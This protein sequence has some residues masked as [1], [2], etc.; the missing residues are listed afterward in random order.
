MSRKPSTPAV[1][2]DA[3]NNTAIAEAGTAAT[4]L[5]LLA[6][7]STERAKTVAVQIGYEGT[8]T[9]GALEDE[10]RFYQR[11]TVE[12]ILETGK[13]LLLLRELSQIGTE[14][15]KRVELLGFSRSTAYRFMQAASKTAASASL[16]ALSTQV[17]SASAFLELVTHDEDDLKAIAEMDDVDRMSAS[18]LRAALRDSRATVDATEKVLADKSARI[19]KLERDAKKQRV[20]LT[21]YPAEFEGY[22]AQVQ[23]AQRAIANKVGALDVIRLEAMQVEP[24]EGEDESLNK[25]RQMLAV[26]MGQAVQH[27][28]DLVDALRLSF[29]KT[30]GAWAE[31]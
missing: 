15:D 13:R 3:A 31:E 27:A 19:T 1:V 21:D 5:T 17:K 10:I 26:A 8:L 23:E 22:I 30:L 11:R 14:F 16:A 4:E 28:A 18:E 20:A 29:D 25:A 12:A 2:I 6:S 9:V 7:E 24:A